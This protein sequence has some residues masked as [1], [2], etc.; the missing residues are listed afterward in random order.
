[1]EDPSDP[2]GGSQVIR[3]DFETGEERLRLDV[4]YGARGI[5]V[6]PHPEDHDEIWVACLGDREP[7]TGYEL[8]RIVGDRP[9]PEF[10]RVPL[11]SG[12]PKGPFGIAST[13]DGYKYVACSTADEIWKIGPDG[14]PVVDDRWPVDVHLPPH[15][16]KDPLQGPLS[17]AIDRHEKIWVTFKN[18]DRIV[19]LAP[20][21]T[22]EIDDRSARG[23][24]AGRPEM[25]GDFTGYWTDLALFP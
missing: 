6:D 22:I 16:G 13:R 11:G 24:T 5:C 2:H 8:V 1:M 12:E 25:L 19:R 15:P 9:R 10:E 7:G 21:G 14:R 18:Y 4:P 20:D 3:Y 23:G 17:V